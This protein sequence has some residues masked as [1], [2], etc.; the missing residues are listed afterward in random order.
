MHVRNSTCLR[1]LC[2]RYPRNQILFLSRLQLAIAERSLSRCLNFFRRR[3]I[4]MSTSVGKKCGKAHDGKC[5]TAIHRLR[6]NTDDRTGTPQGAILPESCTSPYPKYQ[7]HERH[8]TCP[9]W[10]V[11]VVGCALK[12]RV[13]ICIYSRHSTK[14]VALQ[15]RDLPMRPVMSKAAGTTRL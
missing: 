5:A 7:F 14:N 4:S 6:L 10:S 9:N 11:A 3:Q 12:L 1:L 13:S 15:R 8:T 2:S